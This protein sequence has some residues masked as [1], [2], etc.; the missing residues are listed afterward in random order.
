[1]N[2]AKTDKKLWLAAALLLLVLALHF[3]VNRNLT[4]YSDDYWYGT[5]FRGG[6]RGF[7]RNT[8]DHYKTT[9]GRVL[10]HILI[11]IVLLFDTKLFAVIAPPLTAAL[12]AA[13]LAAQDRR[14]RR[15]PLLLGTA[16]AVL[17]VLGSEIQYLR[18]SLYWLSA[19]FNYAFPLL[20]PLLTLWLL[21]RGGG[22]GRSGRETAALCLCALLSGM[23]TEQMGVVS[24]T[25]LW[26]FWLLS[27]F[28]RE[29]V[30]SAALRCALLCSAGYVTILLAPGSHARMERGIEGGVLSVLRPAVFERRFFDVMDYLC[31]CGYWNALFSAVCLLSAAL[32]LAAKRRGE[33]RPAAL[34]LGFPAAAAVGLLYALKAQR[35]LAVVTVCATLALAGALLASRDT[36]VTGLLLLGGGASVMLLTVTTLYYARTFFPCVLLFIAAAW[37]L[38]LRDAR[39]EG[40]P[41][42]TAAVCGALALLLLARYLPIYRGYERNR[43]VTDRNL[44]AVAAARV[45]APLVLS[46][47]PE[48][49][50]RFTEFFEGGY[51]LANFLRYYR[52]PEDIPVRFTSELWDV[53]GL[54]LGERT[55]VFPA[56]EKDG[57]LLLPIEFVFQ[58]LGERCDFDWTN[59]SFTLTRTGVTYVLEETGRL[60]GDGGTA[61]ENCRYVMPFSFTYTLLYLSEEDFSRCFGISFAYDGAADEYLI[62]EGS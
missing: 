11:P 37:S 14:L 10:V 12:F 41:L 42:G 53:S 34:L 17:T 48:P 47:D 44:A 25:A 58:A 45:G 3:A 8:V 36:R 57:T 39:L 49:D 46:V 24:L 5:F 4:V 6:L 13:G 38:L 33:K 21:E 9:N 15:A 52:L 20:F 19:F 18:M 16:M 32:W 2:R 31:G 60:T 51:F 1:M 61:E 43:A 29:P 40:R 35:P 7:V 59:H 26:G 30:K 50:Y 22:E 27:H 56:L 54:R 23:G 55:A 62:V 28:G